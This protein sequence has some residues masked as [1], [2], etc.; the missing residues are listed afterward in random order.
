MENKMTRYNIC[1][2]KFQKRGSA[3][4]WEREREVGMGY[5]WKY[6]GW[7]FPSDAKNSKYINNHNK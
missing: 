3:E 2:I 6:N 4:Q 5:I 1:V 7:E